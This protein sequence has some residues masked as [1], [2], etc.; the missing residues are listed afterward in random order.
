MNV[1]HR[2]ID[3]S[4]SAKS[5]VYHGELS[6]VPTTD[7]DDIFSRKLFLK[8]NQYIK[9]YEE[10]LKEHRERGSSKK[11]RTS[12]LKKEDITNDKDNGDDGLDDSELFDPLK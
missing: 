11:I 4:S 12:L 3:G 7:I 10:G 9:N 2:N 6:H 5:G 8:S 1:F